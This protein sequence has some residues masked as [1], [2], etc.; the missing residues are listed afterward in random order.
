MGLKEI[1]ILKEFTKEA[2]RVTLDYEVGSL[3]ETTNHNRVLNTAEVLSI[4]Y[5]STDANFNDIDEAVVEGSFVAIDSHPI[6]K[7]VIDKVKKTR[8]YK[9][10]DG[11]EYWQ[12]FITMIGTEILLQ[13]TILPNK[14]LT[15]L[16]VGQPKKVKEMMEEYCTVFF[17][18]KNF[19]IDEDL[20]V[21]VAYADASEVAQEFTWMKTS[22]YDIL[23]DL[24]GQKHFLVVWLHWHYDKIKL[25]IGGRNLT[26]PIN[27]EITDADI[28]RIEIN[29]NI[30]ANP[31]A[32]SV[33]IGN[34]MIGNAYEVGI[35]QTTD[36]G[37]MTTDD[38]NTG[39]ETS[40]GI[41]EIEEAIIV[42]N[43]GARENHP[44]GTYK[45]D[46][47]EYIILQEIYETMLLQ[48]TPPSIGVSPGASKYRNL[49]LY[50][51]KGK[52]K[53][54]G[55]FFPLKAKFLFIDTGVSYTL[56][57]IIQFIEAYR[58]ELF[59][60][61]P[62]WEDDRT[63]YGFYDD[64]ID[65]FNLNIKYRTV[66]EVRY[67]I[68]KEN[69][70]G[71]LPQN[72]SSVYINFDKYKDQQQDILEKFTGAEKVA[73]GKGKVIVGSK[74][75]ED[76]ILSQLTEVEFE[77]F[78]DW[79]GIISPKTNRI[80]SDAYINT[81]K[82][83]YNIKDVEDSIRRYD[84][85]EQTHSI[86]QFGT[87]FD[88]LGDNLFFLLTTYDKYNVE[89][90]K[91]LLR[92]MIYS[93]SDEMVFFA[94]ALDNKYIGKK[95]TMDDGTKV[96][97]GVFYTDENTGE[98]YN[99]KIELISHSGLPDADFPDASNLVGYSTWFSIEEAIKLKDSGEKIAFTIKIKKG[100]M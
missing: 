75:G 84:Y 72:Q 34:A 4:I 8:L 51:E 7:Y 18:P 68:I 45:F 66:E 28:D 90:Q 46:I 56:F 69:G 12:F 85:F 62:E 38:E 24:I 27:E 77:G 36:I 76:E 14:S 94:K 47:T 9:D 82:R 43:L 32:L 96:T 58:P 42:A 91:T 22:L 73:Y 29:R 11:T 48:P 41:N 67:D 52:N 95:I 3:K 33:D 88:M 16:V 86:T 35:P 20:E 57:R 25:E 74:Y 87:L 1:T 30:E 60:E 6:Y 65:K 63:G 49:Y 99:S 50:Y 61:K 70:F 17:E 98:F 78:I 5:K 100:E 21:M 81:Q 64:E 37:V 89:L 93:S 44:A 71:V 55:I 26:E 39:W 79:M 19:N 83:F 15:Q 97:D 54:G 53:I 40:F 59:I 92:P 31:K 2:Y 23:S 10:D 13:K 80:D